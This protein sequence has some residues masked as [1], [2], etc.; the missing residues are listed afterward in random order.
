VAWRR[1]RRIIDA[2][3]VCVPAKFWS[4][5]LLPS[6]VLLAAVAWESCS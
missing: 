1:K 2:G 5:A 4:L 6:L 3:T